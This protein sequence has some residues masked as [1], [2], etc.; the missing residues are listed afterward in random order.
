MNVS[1]L[2]SFF[3]ESLYVPDIKAKEKKNVLKELIQPLVKINRVASPGL[4]LETLMRRETLGSTGLGKGVAVPHCRTLAVRDINVVVG[5]SE[6]GVEYQ[7]V[8]KKKVQLF[9]LI[10]APPQ[11][12]KNLYLP[13]LG[14]IVEMVRDGKTRKA[15]L[16]SSDYATFLDV[17]QGG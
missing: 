14:K 11:E 17:I 4:V 6:K 16:K 12:D 10:I 3:N 9:F 5:L 1:E 15:L 13:L 8:D 2:M 7:A